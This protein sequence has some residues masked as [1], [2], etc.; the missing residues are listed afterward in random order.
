MYSLYRRRSVYRVCQVVS[1]IS[2]TKKCCIEYIDCMSVDC[3][4]DRTYACSQPIVDERH[5]S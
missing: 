2:R 5:A 3:I 1:P 4:V